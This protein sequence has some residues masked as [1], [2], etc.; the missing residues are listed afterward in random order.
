MRVSTNLLQIGCILSEDV[1]S[2][3]NKPII[4]KK[5]VL[6][7]ELLDILEIFMIKDVGVEAALVNGE[8]FQPAEIIVD[9]QRQ[10][11]VSESEFL[12]LYLHAV[13][14]YKKLFSSWQAGA[15]IDIGKVRNVIIPL[16]EKAMSRP[17]QLFMLHHYSTKED[18]IYHHSVSVA[19]MS[20][21]IASKLNY[22]QGDCNQITLAG[23][24]SDCGM[25]KID[26][27][28]LNKKQPLTAREYEE[29]K[30]HP[31]YSY[32]M[33]RNIPILKEGAKLAVFQHHERVDGSGYLLAIMGDQ[34]H[35]FGKIV[36]VADVYQAMTSE[37]PYRT[38]QSQYKVLEQII[39]EFFG[40]FD[41]H[42][43]NALTS[44]IAN[45]S[46]G[47]RVRLSNNMTGEIVFIEPNQPTRPMVKDSR[48][49]D[50]IRL[51]SNR[52]LYIEEIL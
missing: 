8:P 31:S 16:A 26:P 10:D 1:F 37:R 46:I 7:R 17:D 20:G 24:L 36:A 12:P 9:A 34:L 41:L 45:F 35:P 44:A 28:I 48:T 22:D 4:P 27:S 15:P 32:K 6:S 14:E 52:D 29:I 18:Y 51:A 43:V 40:K 49:G 47:S 42:V 23:L 38:K 3:T 5:T 33:I 11:S 2:L 19:L 25:A 21:Y 13:K 50:I 30:Q 39:Q